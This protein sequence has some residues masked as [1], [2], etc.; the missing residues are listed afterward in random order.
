MRMVKKI[1]IVRPLIPKIRQPG[2]M[3]EFP[4]QPQPDEV[5]GFMADLTCLCCNEPA[6]DHVAGTCLFNWSTLD[7]GDVERRINEL[8][9]FN[10]TE[11]DR[12]LGISLDAHGLEFLE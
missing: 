2:N 9:A 8:P 11:L 3:R 5:V 6:R 10:V 4:P 12:A 7:L 1:G